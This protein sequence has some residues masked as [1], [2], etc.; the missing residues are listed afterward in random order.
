MSGRKN[1]YGRVPLLTVTNWPD[2]KPKFIN[3]AQRFGQAGTALLTGVEPAFT[4]PN[5]K[6]IIYPIIADAVL[7][8]HGNAV[9][10]D[11]GLPRV[12]ARRK[13]TDDEFGRVIFLED[14]KLVKRQQGQYPRDRQHLVEFLMSVI[15]DE[16]DTNMRNDNDFLRCYESY[17]ILELWR[18]AENAAT[19]QGAVAIHTTVTRLLNIK[20]ERGKY[21]TY[22]QEFNEIVGSLL[23]LGD[24]Q[25]LLQTIFNTLFVTRADPEEF[26]VQI[27][28]VKGTVK[29]KNYQELGAEWRVFSSTTKGLL[30]LR[31]LQLREIWSRSHVVELPGAYAQVHHLWE[32]SFRKVLL[33]EQWWRWT[34]SYRERSWSWKWRTKWSHESSTNGSLAASKGSSSCQ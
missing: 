23:R 4:L 21:G 26:G 10:G 15:D 29:W 30:K 34:C 33:S 12:Q 8:E 25:E 19:G 24:A 9:I 11:D 2:F 16:V 1:G 17:S 7:D 6:E 28:A 27:A 5:I 14:L 3:S 18:M 20:Q 22:L 32:E 31:V 13:Y